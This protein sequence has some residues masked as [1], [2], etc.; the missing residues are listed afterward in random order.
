MI[1]I[2][3]AE[4]VVATEPPEWDSIEKPSGNILTGVPQNDEVGGR[5]SASIDAM[6][7]G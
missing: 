1:C 2:T 7:T 5:I 4:S 6:E 3:R